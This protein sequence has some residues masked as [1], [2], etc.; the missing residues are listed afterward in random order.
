MPWLFS[1]AARR[2]DRRGSGW[3]PISA[4]GRRAAPAALPRDRPRPVRCGRAARLRHAR[5]PRRRRWRNRSARRVWGRCRRRR[6]V[7]AMSPSRCEK[8]KQSLRHLSNT[9]GQMLRAMAR[10]GK[11][12]PSLK[13]RY[14]REKHDKNIHLFSRGRSLIRKIILTCC[15]CRIISEPVGMAI[16]GLPDDRMQATHSCCIRPM[17]TDRHFQSRSRLSCR[18]KRSLLT[19]ELGP[20]RFAEAA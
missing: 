17:A 8:R 10:Q 18:R 3:P 16:N 6:P 14:H 5:R 12:A 1:A 20:P 15:H 2:R 19:D 13:K 9:S 11:A 7:A 4:R